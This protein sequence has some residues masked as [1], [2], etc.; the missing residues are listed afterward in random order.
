MYGINNGAEVLKMKVMMIILLLLLLLLSLLLLLLVMM[1][2]IAFVLEFKEG[3]LLIHEK[4][5]K[6]SI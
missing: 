2:P 4:L 3:C 1:L 5:K 6:V